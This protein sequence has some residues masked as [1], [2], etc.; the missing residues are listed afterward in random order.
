[1]TALRPARINRVK[2]T[3]FISERMG[4]PKETLERPLMIWMP[5]QKGEGK[6]A[7]HE[8]L[9]L[10]DHMGPCIGNIVHRVGENG[11][12]GQDHQGRS[13]FKNPIG[14]ARIK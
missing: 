5:Y 3:L 10:P 6:G 9:K 7:E 1:M 13:Q 4:S 11:D 2:N 12:S 8:K 14:A